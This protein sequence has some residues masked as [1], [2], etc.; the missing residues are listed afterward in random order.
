MKSRF[1]AC[2]LAMAS[3]QTGLAEFK[4]ALPGYHYQFPRDYFDHPDYQT[5][6]WYYTGNITG[7]DGRHFGF[8]LTFFREGVSRDGLKTSV[9]DVRDI[10]M[11]HF[12]LSD[13]DA[14]RFYHVER[15]NRAGP[16][17]AGID[18][19]RQRIWN[20]NWSSEWN[21]EIQELRA[22]D[23]H[24]SISLVLR[25]QKA[26][27]IH[28]ENG[29]SQK[30]EGSG[31]AS[32]YFSFT[33]LVTEGAIAVDGKTIEVSGLSWMDHE[34]FT[35]QLAPDQAGWDWLGVELD[36]N[37]ELMLYRLRRNDGTA[38]PYSAG[39]YVDPQGKSRHLG[40][41]DFSFLPQADSW[42]SPVGSAKYPVAWTIAIPELGM[43]L[44]ATTRLKSQEVSSGDSK[45]V[46]TYWEGAITL[47]G[48][49]GEVGLKGVGYLEM[50]GY[51]RPV[52]FGPVRLNR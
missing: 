17:I 52:R 33:R 44:N 47:E 12:A 5:E 1:M 8:E 4:T 9:W 31:H 2:V 36:D 34:F 19:N 24:F 29:V 3:G 50:T 23:E 7:R 22:L 6:W 51:D 37:S 41:G 21:G 38:D 32:H 13:L 15:V 11:A 46:P 16:G 18:A 25:P 26:P 48:H 20:G 28:G 27:V 42:T 45:L 39:T 14:G 10:Y 40:A 35:H 43:Q 30:A 49:R